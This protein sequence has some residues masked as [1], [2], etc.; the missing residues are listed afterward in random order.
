MVF[1]LSYGCL[2]IILPFK[3]C[4]NVCVLLCVHA[5]QEEARGNIQSLLAG[6]H[7][8]LWDA[9]LVNGRL[10]LTLVLM[11]LKLVLLATELSLLPIDYNF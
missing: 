8:C 5:L 11:I 2:I 4:F 10:V 7:R 6:L 1:S 9:S 3:K